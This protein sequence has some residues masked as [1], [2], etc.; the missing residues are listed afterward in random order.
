[1][2]KRKIFLLT[3]L[4]LVTGMNFAIY[5]ADEEAEARKR[6]KIIK[7]LQVTKAVKLGI[8]GFLKTIDLVP[9]PDTDKKLFKKY[10]TEESLRNAIIPVYMKVMTEAEI[11]AWLQFYATDLGRSIADKQQDLM[12]ESKKASLKWHSEI[13]VKVRTEKA[14]IEAEKD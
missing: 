1:M 6:E 7:F 5:A 8:D 2:R 12:D 4:F 3:V 10:A 13:A 14:K 9:L 11:D